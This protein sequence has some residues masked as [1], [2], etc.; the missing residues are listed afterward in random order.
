MQIGQS[1]KSVTAE[2]LLHFLRR[3]GYLETLHLHLHNLTAAFIQNKLQLRQDTKEQ[4]M[5][6]E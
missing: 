1:V 5:I 3:C 2:V 4:L 6:N